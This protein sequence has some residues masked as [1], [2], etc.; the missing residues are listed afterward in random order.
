MN[1]LIV[2]AHPEPRSLNGALTAFAAAELRR[3]GHD[4]RVSDL[5]AMRWRPGVEAGDFPGHDPDERLDVIGA[6]GRAYAEGSLAPD[7]AAEQEKLLWS[8]ALILQFPMWWFSMPAVLKGWVDRVFTHGFGYG[9][10]TR[11]RALYG[12]GTLAG[13]RAMVSLTIGA[14]ERSFSARGVHGHLDDLLFPIQHGL[15]YYTGMDVLP[16]FAVWD[17]I[18]IGE[19]RFAAITEAYAARLRALFTDEPI[20]YRPLAGGDYTRTMELRPELDSGAGGLAV[21]VRRHGP[22]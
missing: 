19:A 8:D 20:A 12:D 1:I 3:A 17:S 15:L 22:R 6:S 13:R 9:V 2:T 10:G 4:V 18:E 16:P 5:Y 7:I 14:A 21:H 11:G